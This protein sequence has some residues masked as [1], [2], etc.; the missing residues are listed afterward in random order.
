MAFT[1]KY[2]VKDAETG[3]QIWTAYSRPKPFAL[4][5]TT[6]CTVQLNVTESEWNGDMVRAKARLEKMYGKPVVLELAGEVE[7]FSV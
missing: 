2:L 5:K 3:C 1:K 4:K 7:Y 6:V